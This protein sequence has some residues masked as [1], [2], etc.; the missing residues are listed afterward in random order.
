MQG[1]RYCEDE[2]GAIFGVSFADELGIE[3]D[4]GAGC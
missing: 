4:S 1:S 2:V 3:G